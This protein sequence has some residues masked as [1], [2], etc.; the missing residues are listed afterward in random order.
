S[1]DLWRDQ[2]LKS[3]LACEKPAGRS[4][5]ICHPGSRAR[6]ASVVIRSRALMKSWIILIVLA[7][8][9]TAA[10]T[11]AL[12]FLT[13]DPSVKGPEFPAPPKSEGPAPVLAIEE[14]LTYQFGVMAQQTQ[15]KH[16]W[17]IKNAGAGILEL[18]GSS[19]TCSCTTSDL[20]E[21]KAGKTISIKPGESKAISV[22]WNTK[23]NDGHYRQTVNVGTNDPS[24]PEFVFVVEGTVRPALVTL[25]PDPSINFSI[26][27]NDEPIRHRVALYSPDRP[28]LKLIRVVSS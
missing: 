4:H 14:N 23:S 25:P 24:R 17:V 28:D 20:F 10:V 27:S 16:P 5:L 3:R 8:A 21:G 18:I 11:V 9:I 7:V 2:G 22:T 26:V 13:A 12:P 15:G 1:L 6:T 19:T